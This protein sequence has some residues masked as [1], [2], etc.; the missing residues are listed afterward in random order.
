[1]KVSFASGS[2]RLARP[3]AGVQPPI[4]PVARGGLETALTGPLSSL[5]GGSI[6]GQVVPVVYGTAKVPGK[7]AFVVRDESRLV[8]VWVY[9]MGLVNTPSLAADIIFNGE[10]AANITFGSWSFKNGNP[11]QIVLTPLTSLGS[12]Y[13]FS[14]PG[15]AL[16]CLDIPST[17][18][19][20]AGSLNLE[21]KTGGRIIK[22]FRNPGAPA[23]IN[24][25][26]VCIA[27]DILTST[28]PWPGMYTDADLDLEN[29]TEW[30]DWCEETQVTRFDFKNGVALPPVA[31]NQTKWEFN[32]AITDPNPLSAANKVLAVAHMSL[33]NV[34]GKIRI[35]AEA[36][37]TPSGV[38]VGAGRFFGEPEIT[39]KYP[40]GIPTE[41]EVAYRARSDNSECSIFYRE[42]SATGRYVK[43]G[44]T[45]N[46]CDLQ[47]QALRWAEQKA[48]LLRER[49]AVRLVTGP[50]VAGVFPGDIIQADLPYGFGMSYIR[51]ISTDQRHDTGKYSITGRIVPD[52]VES[53]QDGNEYTGKDTG[54][55][56]ETGTPNAPELFS[57]AIHS[58]QL[59]R[60]HYQPML[61]A[62]WQPPKTGPRVRYYE[63][64]QDSVIIARVFGTRWTGPV[65]EIGQTR[66]SC[67]AVGFD[68]SES[69]PASSGTYDTR[70]G[71]VSGLNTVPL[72]GGPQDGGSGFYYDDSNDEMVPGGASYTHEYHDVS[73]SGTTLDVTINDTTA[74]FIG[75]IAT[76]QGPNAGNN[77]PS[78]HAI[79][80]TVFRLTFQTAPPT[81]TPYNIIALVTRTANSYDADNNPIPP[82]GNESPISE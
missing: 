79:S 32:G 15:F 67:V 55:G 25:N 33:V 52:S 70:V 81:H 82:P 7:L 44:V 77:T 17:R 61:Y 11:Q 45:L 16:V 60:D 35:R 9:A 10:P 47:R 75:A 57:A 76:Q 56:W 64:L 22:D 48:K 8:L 1:M 27:Y 71:Y 38:V 53:I 23:A 12:A 18:N 34:G 24:K 30:A 62:E 43:L 31:I 72:S 21:V 29:W 50:E 26:P 19:V 54:G 58:R 46:G 66:F 68:G 49:W 65:L 36:D 73:T 3:P 51:V 28:W 40:D 80:N 5:S 41:I 59:S 69:A 42:P 4:P 13:E 2:G 37:V 74:M 78:I 20:D 39:D 63:L 14:Y 6:M